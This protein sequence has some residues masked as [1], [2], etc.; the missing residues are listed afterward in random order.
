MDKRTLLAVAIS[1][2]IIIVGFVVQSVIASRSAQSPPDSRDADPPQGQQQEQQQPTEVEPADSRQ[3]SADS[4]IRAAE[5]QDGFAECDPVFDNGTYRVTFSID[6]ASIESLLLLDH[7]TDDTPVEMI[8]RGGD[9]PTPFTVR[10]GGIDGEP[11]VANFSCVKTTS[12]IAFSGQFFVKDKE[13]EPFTLNKI[14]RF[15]EGEYLFEVEISLENSVNQAVPLGDDFAAYTLYIGPQI[16][17]AFAKLNNRQNFR[18]YVTL[19]NRNRDRLRFRR[20][21]EYL[22]IDPRVNWTAVT[23]KYFS[24]AVVPH[25]GLKEIRITSQETADIPSTS[26]IHLIR[27]PIH[28]SFERDVYQVYVGPKLKRELAKFNDPQDNGLDAS[29]L[30]LER[31]IDPRPLLGWLETLLRWVLTGIYFVIPNYG[32]AIIILT[33]IVKALLLPLT[34]KSQRSMERMQSLGPKIKEI[35]EKFEHDRQK[36]NMEMAS[37][38]K[39]EGVNPAGGCLPL[40]AQFPIFIAMYGIFSNH[41][42]L[43]NAVFIP[44]WIDDLSSPES[45]YN[46][47]EFVIPLLN[48]N[49]LRL[50]PIFFVATSIA[51]ALMNKN[52][53]QN[54]QQNRIMMLMP[55][56][57]FFVLY[58]LP[59]GL[60]LYWTVTNILTIAQQLVNRR[61]RLAHGS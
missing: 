37:L 26:E 24:L 48:W 33:I 8:F 61:K 42:E 4:S 2:I 6:T 57:L 30:A 3:G 9:D 59:S 44:G 28:A 43:R 20:N 25:S 13:D 10:N 52:P 50:L 14:Y 16:G 56:V 18:R 39:R 38:Y 5:P 15:N 1:S 29:G 7:L 11:L 40:I 58:N 54:E 35:R 31:V 41:F 46:F 49:D 27:S 47:G 36:L 51:S 55:I 12:S 32:V 22:S 21:T 19:T 53:A 45:I 23:G 17:P 34:N 60:L